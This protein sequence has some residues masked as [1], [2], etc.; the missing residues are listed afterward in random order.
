MCVCECIYVNEYVCITQPISEC[1]L[2][3]KSVLVC[4]RVL[5]GGCLC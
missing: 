2:V 1:V 3:S 5:I 4:L